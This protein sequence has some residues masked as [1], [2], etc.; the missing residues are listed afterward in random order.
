VQ[1]AGVLFE[2]MK[3]NQLN[4]EEIA[5]GLKP[6]LKQLVQL[7]EQGTVD[8]QYYV[9]GIMA[10]LAERKDLTRALNQVHAK[11]PVLKLTNSSNAIIRNAADHTI[12]LLSAQ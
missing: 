8:L 2:C 5:S 12:R 1:A 3:N 11:A 6:K 9:L 4:R 7:L 10:S